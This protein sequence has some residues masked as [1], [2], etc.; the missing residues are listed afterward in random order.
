MGDGE[1]IKEDYPD[2]Y[3]E[4][5]K[6]VPWSKGKVSGANQSFRDLDEQRYKL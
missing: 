5:Y 2:L 1:R 6:R 4:S 3:P